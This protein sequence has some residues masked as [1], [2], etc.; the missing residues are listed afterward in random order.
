MATANQ[1]P[2]PLDENTA[3]DLKYMKGYVNVLKERFTRRSLGSSAFE[4]FTQ[5]PL[6]QISTPTQPDPTT[7]TTTNTNKTIRMSISDYQ[8][9]KQLTALGLAGNNCRLAQSHSDYQRRRSVSPFTSRELG[10]ATSA[11][12]SLAKHNFGGYFGGAGAASPT[13]AAAA[14]SKR[15]HTSGKYSRDV[16]S[17]LVEAKVNANANAN[18]MYAKNVKKQFAS[19]EDLCSEQPKSPGKLA[20]GM[21]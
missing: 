21:Y 3:D 18:N 6:L 4:Q 5:D 16:C 17:N 1:A 20:S 11:S 15:I 19:S 2:T 12:A 14:N 9:R 13:A 7:T 10:L 8:R